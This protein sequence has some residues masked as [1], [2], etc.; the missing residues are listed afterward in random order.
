MVVNFSIRQFFYPVIICFVPL[1]YT[2]NQLPKTA[3]AAEPPKTIKPVISRADA[4]ETLEVS[5]AEG[6]LVDVEELLLLGPPV[7]VDVE[8]WMLL[9]LFPVIFNVA[10]DAEELVEACVEL[11][12]WLSPVAV[13]VSV[14]LLATPLTFGIAVASALK[15]T[16][17]L[18]VEL[19]FV[20]ASATTL[21]FRSYTTYADRRNVSPR[22]YCS[23]EVPN[24][25][26]EGLIIP[27]MQI[28]WKVTP[29]GT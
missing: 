3:N 6:P 7:D 17:E 15:S 23:S 16:I 19:K 20:C 1:N 21:F 29:E 10:V 12:C 9:E 8:D 13:A 18:V 27:K 2:R 24:M 14:T 25:L 4:D 26:V 28:C 22:M 5:E 11:A